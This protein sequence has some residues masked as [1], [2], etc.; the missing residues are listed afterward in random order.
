MVD[1]AEYVCLFKQ[2]CGSKAGPGLHLHGG[3]MVIRR[4]SNREGLLFTLSAFT[5]VQGMQAV[6]HTLMDQSAAVEA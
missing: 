6:S 2:V 1:T 5:H 3:I 4:R